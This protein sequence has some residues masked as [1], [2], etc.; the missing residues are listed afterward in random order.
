MQGRPHEFAQLPSQDTRI[1]A[2]AFLELVLR[3]HATCTAY[4]LRTL[5]LECACAGGG[6]S[7]FVACLISA[8]QMSC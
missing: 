8:A 2:K 4:D 7:V 6:L 1:L 5:F 3:S